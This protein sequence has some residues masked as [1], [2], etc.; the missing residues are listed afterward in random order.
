M[1]KK[2]DEARFIWQER[3]IRFDI[4]MA[5][6]ALFEGEQIVDSMNYVEDTKGNNGDLGSIIITNLRLIWFCD[7]DKHINLSIGYDCIISSDI[8]NV[9][10]I[11]RGGISQALHLRTKFQT[12][13]YEFVFT[14]AAAENQGRMFQ[15][16][17]HVTKSYNMT[18]LYRDLKLRAANISEK[19][20]RMMPG[21]QVFTRYHG[22]MN[23]SAE[24][25]N[26]GQFVI[27]NVR[28]IWFA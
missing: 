5:Q 22:V 20:I 13:K 3:E 2:T 16:F 10:S 14:C 21:E 26:L 15:T 12:S 8:K 27:T 23:L 11:L 18:R 24:Q 28:I 9:N 4:A 6:L 1:L 7:T 19:N 25:G 17:Q